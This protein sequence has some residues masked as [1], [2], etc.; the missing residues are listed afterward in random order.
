MYIDIVQEATFVCQPST[1]PHIDL[2]IV[3]RLLEA[4]SSLRMQVLPAEKG[5]FSYWGQTNTLIL[6][7]VYM[8]V[9]PFLLERGRPECVHKP[10]G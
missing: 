10:N 5:S 2:S 3:V 9:T 8:S 4:P 1:V 7:L 6:Q